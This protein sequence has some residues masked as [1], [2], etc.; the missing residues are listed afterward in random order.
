MLAPTVLAPAVSALSKKTADR[1]GNQA[2]WAKHAKDGRVLRRSITR[3]NSRK[4]VTATE[5][6]DLAP[7]LDG[8]RANLTG[9]VLGCIEADAKC[10]FEFGIFFNICKIIALP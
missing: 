6:R 3:E 5:L 9:L 8:E 4:S 2:S 7:A 10:F 1:G